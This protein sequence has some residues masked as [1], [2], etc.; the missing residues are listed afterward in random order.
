MAKGKGQGARGK[1]QG[2][3]GKGLG[4]LSGNFNRVGPTWKVENK[5]KLGE[6]LGEMLIT[7]ITWKSF[8]A[9]TLL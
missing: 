8:V 5:P 1:G 6:R 4:V 3:K 2:A 9:V 7:Y